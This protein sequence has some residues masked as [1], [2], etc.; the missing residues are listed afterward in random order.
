[1]VWL[2]LEDCGYEPVGKRR[3]A[4][5]VTSIVAREQAVL[6]IGHNPRA[7]T[8]TR[9]PTPA[10]TIVNGLHVAVA[11]IE[12]VG[13][14]IAVIEAAATVVVGTVENRIHTLWLVAN[15]CSAC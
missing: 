3:V 13:L 1:M 5:V 9:A 14:S 6:E 2:A 11:R 8:S 12:T 10:V 15:S 7:V 4:A